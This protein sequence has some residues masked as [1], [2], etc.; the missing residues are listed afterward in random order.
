MPFRETRLKMMYLNTCPK[1]ILDR[2]MQS[3][4]ISLN[5]NLLTYKSHGKL[6]GK[7]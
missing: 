5:V 4:M 7:P 1:L 6:L 2:M 3:V